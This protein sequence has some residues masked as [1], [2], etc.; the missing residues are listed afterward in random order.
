MI[1][2]ACLHA[3]RFRAPAYDAVGVLLEKGIGCQLAGL[4]AGGA[5]E[6]RMGPLR[7]V[8][9]WSGEQ[10]DKGID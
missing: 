7:P 3:G 10:R 2:D 9:L 6:I 8:V 5:E 4:A 1:A